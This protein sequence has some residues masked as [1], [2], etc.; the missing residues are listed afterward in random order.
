MSKKGF[1]LD[2]ERPDKNF[3]TRELEFYKHLLQKKLP[4]QSYCNKSN[5][6]V[7][8]GIEKVTSE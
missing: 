7:S 3:S 6:P 4:G 1:T 2:L 5:F 8:N